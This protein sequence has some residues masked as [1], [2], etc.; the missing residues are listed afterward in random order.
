[1]LDILSWA[2]HLLML[3]EGS[4]LKKVLIQVYPI[5]YNH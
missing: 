4:P 5:N 3:H 2:R 1:M